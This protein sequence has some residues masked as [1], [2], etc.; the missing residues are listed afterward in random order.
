MYEIKH[1]KHE[2]SIV[3]DCMATDRELPE[4]IANSPELPAYLIMYYDAFHSLHSCR[5][6]GMSVGMIPWD[7][8]H[9]YAVAME[10]DEEQTDDLHY[11]LTQLDLAY[12]KWQKDNS[13]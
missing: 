5:D 12:V 8:V 3:R 4:F 13:G 7:A 10:L 2:A 1:G 9:K 6:M 11:F